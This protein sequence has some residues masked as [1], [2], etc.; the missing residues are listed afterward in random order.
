MP[1]S[2][3]DP[4]D[5]TAYLTETGRSIVG[6]DLGACPF[7]GLVIAK[8]D[9]DDGETGTATMVSMGNGGGTPKPQAPATTVAEAA[10]PPGKAQALGGPVPE[11]TPEPGPQKFVTA[12]VAPAA[13]ERPL[14]ATQPR[15]QSL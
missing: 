7:C 3:Q 6:D 13:G 11:G 4:P 2:S 9:Q 5:R 10:E 14:L 8:A 1:G 15:D 12:G